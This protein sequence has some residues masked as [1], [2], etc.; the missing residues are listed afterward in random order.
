V[1]IGRNCG[2]EE[3]GVRGVIYGWVLWD[4]RDGA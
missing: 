4:V 3:Q 1:R 2:V